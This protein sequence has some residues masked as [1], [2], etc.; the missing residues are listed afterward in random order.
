MTAVTATDASGG[1]QYSFTCVS[2]GPGC[3]NSGWQTSSSFT[4]GGLQAN[5]SYSYSV[6]ARD[7][8][9]N[10]NIASATASATTFNTSPV[11]PAAPSGLTAVAASASQINLSWVDNAGNETGYRVE[12][13]L[14]GSSGWSTVATLGA[15][16]TS[17][18]D[19]GLSANTKYYYRVFA[20]NSAGDSVVSNT[21]N[22]TTNASSGFVEYT[23]Q[24]Q[25]TGEG[26]V[27][28]G[29]SN[30]HADDGSVQ[31]I[32]EQQSGGNPRKRRS[33][34][35]HTWNFNITAG[36]TTTLSANA[37][38]GGSSDGDSFQFQWSADGSSFTNAFVVSSQLTNNQQ[39]AAL[40]NNLSGTVYVRVIDT[41]NSQ[42]NSTTDTVYVDYLVIRVDSTPV[43]PPATPSGLNATAIAY[44]Q[45][46]L[47]WVDN[48][49]AET[50]YE[51]Q[52]STSGG[53][54]T[55]IANLAEN[56]NSYSNVT[57]AAQTTYSYKVRALKGATPSSYSS[58][59]SATTPAQPAGSISLSANGYKVKGSQ[60]ADLTWSGASGTTVDI[61]RNGVVVATTG[62]DG[63]YTD[64]I[65]A[66]GSA[67]YQYKVCNAGSTTACSNIA[68]VVF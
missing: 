15:N 46:N 40:P 29:Y 51:V 20:T 36:N 24:G 48:A 14:N 13:S 33:S 66:K 12:R 49:T 3:S 6:R 34:L 60:K 25:S 1:I 30:T 63:S 28:G 7:A 68:T 52:R 53:A 65:N 17:R 19:T 32:T 22:A 9:G 31:S 11:P 56:A 59:A 44:N 26:S 23:A 42:G 58:P 47:N 54:Y 50:G 37:W 35:T 61:R 55:T 8:A 5:T 18:N 21:A 27:S 4:D 10:M 57:V 16:S 62:N 43:T 64:D 2:G 67:T 45:I 41:D 38:S 39:V